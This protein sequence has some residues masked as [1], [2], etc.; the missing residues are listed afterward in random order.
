MLTVALAALLVGVGLALLAGAA[1]RSRGLQ[2]AAE[3]PAAE[4]VDVDEPEVDDEGNGA[5]LLGRVA[6]PLVAFATAAVGRLSPRSRIELIRHRIVLAG[7]EGSL[8]VGKVL[9]RKG[10]L[11]VVLAIVLGLLGTA[12]SDRAVIAVLF[13]LGGAAL[14]YFLPDIVLG[15]QADARQ[16]EVARDLSEAIDLLAITVESGLGL[17]QALDMVAGEVHGPLG[18]ELHRVIREIGLGV[19]RRQALI[20]LRQRTDVPELSAFIVALVQAEALGM[21]VSEVLKVQ[22]VQVR[23]RRK[24]RAREQAA[25]TPVKILFPVIFG[26]LPALF[27]VVMGPAAMTIYHSILQK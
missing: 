19:P 6:E 4:I 10:L 8:T 27:I 18:E 26:V 9:A 15:H 2:P 20:A 22:A 3:G 21:A 14:G 5:G 13:V 25:K 11:T 17:E 12:V 7:R 1:V 16:Q 23:A 24:A